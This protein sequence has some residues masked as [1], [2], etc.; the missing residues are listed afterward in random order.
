MAKFK[1]KA[2]ALDMLGRQQIASIPTAISELFK[3]AYDAYADHVEVDFFKSDGLFVLRDDGIGMTLEEFE[4]R[5]LT[6]GTE[7]KIGDKS[8]LLYRPPGVSPRPIMGE[9]GIGRLSVALIG[10]QVLIMTR[11]KRGTHLDDLV[12]AF[13]HWRVFSIPGIDL[14]EIEIPIKTFPSDKIPSENDVYDI[15]HKFEQNIYLLKDKYLDEEIEFS[16][17]LSD[18]T[19]FRIHPEKLDIFLPKLSLKESSGTHFFIMASNDAINTL[20]EDDRKN[21]RVNLD[22]NSLS[23]TLLGFTNTMTPNHPKPEI[24]TA[25]RCWKTDTDYSNI[26][27]NKF[28]FTPEEF[29]VAD[30]S[31]IGSFDKYG[32][33]CGDIKIYDDIYK[34]HVINSKFSQKHHTSCGPFKIKF[35]YLMGSSSL[36]K[37]TPEDFVQINSKLERLGGLYI[38]KD[39][40]RILPYGL[41]EFDWLQ[42]EERRTKGLAYYFFSHRR[43]F[44]CIEINQNDNKG[45]TEKAGREGFIQNKAHRELKEILINFFTQLAADFFRKDAAISPAFN[46]VKDEFSKRRK[47]L[48]EREKLAARMRKAFQQELDIFFKK[49]EENQPEQDIELVRSHVKKELMQLEE[50]LSSLSSPST[51]LIELESI[52][53]NQV[54]KIQQSYQIQE[55]E[56]GIP[57]KLMQEWQLAVEQYQDLVKNLFTPARQEVLSMINNKSEELQ[58]IFDKIEKYSMRKQEVEERQLNIFNTKRIETRHSLEELNESVKNKIIDIEKELRQMTH[59]WEQKLNP[60]LFGKMD[61][62]SILSLLE[63]YES[64]LTSIVEKEGTKLFTIKADISRLTWPEDENGILLGTSSMDAALE[65]EILA[66]REK[67]DMD[68]ELV[69]MGMAVSI[70]HHEFDQTIS[71]LRENLRTL[72]AWASNN[73]GL[74]SLYT[75]LRKNF[76]HLDGYLNLFTPLEKRM[77]RRKSYIK[78]FEIKDFLS[79]VFEE[80]LNQDSIVIKTSPEFREKTIQ[81][82]TSTFYA[83]FL[84]LVDNAI[85]WLGSSKKPRLITL[86][87]YNDCFSV[88]DNGP[89]IQLRDRNNVFEFGFTRKPGGRGMGLYIAK[90]VLRKEGFNLI[91][92]GNSSKGTRFYIAPQDKHIQEDFSDAR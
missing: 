76:D 59:E 72:S 86:D 33:F 84:N 67:V 40:I 56:V 81:G 42:M 64:I 1:T 38:Y 19:N 66:L 8:K 57:P 18:L 80:R 39:G 61:E 82:F 23:R 26:I 78:G 75:N 55:P 85:F 50:N 91:L 5:W 83:V 47:A 51:S 89:G 92:A 17:I 21:P 88:A 31:I 63:N 52:V 69:Q 41:P 4:D 54:E 65:D 14:D 77:N 62:K 22:S 87:L 27:E 12:V 70:I 60:K 13:I 10:D 58:I 6:L 79:R 29:K 73:K 28:F 2:R 34:N 37:V 68:V 3:N 24:A 30:H 49:I 74:K 35:A 11:A 53:R 15:V 44:G 46:K 16:N 32:H 90:Q 9:K 7:S 43:I 25:F 20:L 48:A 71:D 45:L 36:S